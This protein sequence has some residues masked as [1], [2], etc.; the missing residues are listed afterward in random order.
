M[1]RMAAKW[2]G[3]TT[4]RQ[5]SHDLLAMSYSDGIGVGHGEAQ[6]PRIISSAASESSQRA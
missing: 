6:S 5:S 1:L 4:R 2:R 3:P